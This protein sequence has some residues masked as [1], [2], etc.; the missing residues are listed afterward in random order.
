M[1]NR[2]AARRISPAMMMSS[3]IFGFA[4]LVGFVYVVFEIMSVQTFY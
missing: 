4:M 3:V 2:A 1:P